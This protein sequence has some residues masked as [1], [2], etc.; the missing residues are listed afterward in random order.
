MSPLC[1]L[2]WGAVSCLLVDLK[3]SL[4]QLQK[5]SG[6]TSCISRFATFYVNA[7]G[8]ILKCWQ[9]LVPDAVGS[10]QQ[11]TW[12]GSLDRNPHAGVLESANVGLRVQNE[13]S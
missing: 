2:L 1:L 6:N 13:W 5:S 7:R 9:V 4:S 10:A 12:A 11:G 3:G 8:T